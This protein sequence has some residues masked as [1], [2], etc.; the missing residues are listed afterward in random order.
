MSNDVFSDIK[1][2]YIQV[3]K[4]LI[5]EARQAS[6]L[7]NSTSVGTEREEVY[8]KF[9]ERHLP[10]ACDAFLGGYVFDLQGNAS[11]QIDVIVTSMSTPTFQLPNQTRIIAPLEGTVAV[12][13]IKSRLD[14]ASLFSALRNFAAIPSMPDSEGIIPPLMSAPKQRWADIPY[15]IILAYDAIQ[16]E[17]LWEYIQEFYDAN[18][19]IPLDRRPNII[20]VLDKYMVI[21]ITPDMR[22][23]EPD[24]TPSAEPIRAGQFRWFHPNSDPMAIAWTLNAI[25]SNA[26][27][28]NQS[29]V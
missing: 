9:L 10:K 2:Y 28:L 11:K 15:K 20:H 3:A 7:V 1:S 26:F 16:R 27:V 12:A 19:H 29:L 4:N 24:G 13:E 14:K 6:L 23:L 5:A 18:G 25:Q 21:R 22:I 17:R 8:R